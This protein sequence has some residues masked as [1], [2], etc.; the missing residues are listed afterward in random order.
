MGGHRQY[1]SSGGFSQYFYHQVGDIISANGLSAK[2]VARI[3]PKDDNQGLPIYSN[4]GELYFGKG[5]KSGEIIQ[6]R[7][8]KNRKAFIDFDW[9]H[10]H[11][12]A[13]KGIVH[14]HYY[15]IGIN[16]NPEKIIGKYRLM[17]N[18][19]MKKYG[20]LIK[21]ANPNAKFR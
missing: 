2:V 19:E 13:P 11:Y 10:P 21:K 9:G 12:G 20:S 6:L 4:T 5:N 3:D 14:V 8:Y 17:N 7:L 18:A 15:K 16:G 1:Q